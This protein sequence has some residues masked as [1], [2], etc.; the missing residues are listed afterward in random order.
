MLRVATVLALSIVWF[1]LYEIGWAFLADGTAKVALD[2][3]LFTVFGVA[4]SWI[5]YRRHEVTG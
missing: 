3:V 5:S 1:A 4:T 2:V